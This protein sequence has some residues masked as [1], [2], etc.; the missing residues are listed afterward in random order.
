MAAKLHRWN[1]KLVDFGFA[2]PLRP[3][4]ILDKK[5][6]LKRKEPR[7]EFFGRSTVDNQLDDRSIHHSRFG[8]DLSISRG[9]ENNDLSL[10]SSISRNKVRNLSAVGNRIFAAP[11]IKKGIR[12]FKLLH[13]KKKVDSTAEAAKQPLSECV[14]DYGMIVDAFS[15]GAT[16]RYM[17]TGAPP[18]VSVEEFILE[19]NSMINVLGRKI[20]KAVNKDYANKRQKRY[21][22]NKDLPPNAVRLILGLTHWNE[23]KRTTVRSARDYEWVNSSYSM[24]SSKAYDP[25]GV[26][27][28]DLDFLKCATTKP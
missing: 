20:K 1:I 22:Y 4:D 16:I 27:G 2:R 24:K 9:K 14:S 8:L 25:F 18:N 5:S 13:S 19:K 11:E 21:R 17:C 23:K 26:Q 10:S 6:L 15:T 12:V 3:E 7:D 28:G